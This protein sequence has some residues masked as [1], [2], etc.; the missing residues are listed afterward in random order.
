MKKLINST[1]LK[2]AMFKWLALCVITSF[3]INAAAGID[4]EMA[5]MFNSMGVE[6]NYTQAGAF[7][8][9]TGSLYTGGSLSVRSPV[10]DVNLSHIQLPSINA[11]CGGIDFFGGAFSF[12]NKEQFIQFTRNLG[13]NAAGVAF[14][15]ALKALDPMIQ[16]AIGG[17][18]D[19]VNNINQANL[20]SCQMSKQLVGG[21]MGKL[22]ESMTA[23][24][25]VAS[26]SNGNAEDGAD[27]SFRCQYGKNLVHEAEK[28]RGSNTPQ[29]TISFTGGNLT[30]EALKQVGKVKLGGVEEDFFYSLVGTAIFMPPGQK[31]GDTSDEVNVR[32]LIFEPTITTT[33]AL[34]GGNRGHVRSDK[35]VV[36]MISCTDG[37]KKM[38]ENCTIVHDV[39]MP[40]IRYLIKQQIQKLPEK[41][42]KNE[43]WSAT[44][45]ED[46]AVI[47]NNTRLPVLQMGVT[48]AFLGSNTLNKEAVIDAIA[49]DYVAHILDKYQRTL[50]SALGLYNKT[51]EVSGKA[52]DRMFDNL[53]ELR[54]TVMQERHHALQAIE[55][56]RN[57]INAIAQFD[58]Q[59]R[60]QFIEI[61]NS[62]SFDEANRL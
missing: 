44:E 17:I 39:E 30:Y 32:P 28:A 9:Q 61:N 52:L 16:D 46:L 7:H 47:V 33:A 5:D 1:T 13:N 8:G 2:P 48:D 27:A 26:V 22:G 12:V 51:D 21:L 6:A 19:L 24:C 56:E 4:N 31:G 50:R 62:L 10:S 38:K 42:A 49:I 18:R 54:S 29:D 55:V 34:L 58:T 43:L 37:P 14:D 45:I 41:I 53:S 15:L 40:S 20:N 25:K 23:N 59:W 36:D 3:P 60:S 57:M 11:G 35:V